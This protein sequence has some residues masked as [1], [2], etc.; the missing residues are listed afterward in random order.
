MTKIPACVVAATLLLSNWVAAAAQAQTQAQAQTPRVTL[1]VA[2]FPDLDRAARAALPRWNQL[3]PG[4]AVKI[5][6]LQYP[7]HHTAM[8]TALATGSGLPDVMAVDFRFIGRFAEGGGLEDLNGAPYGAGALRDKFVRYTFMQATSSTG[9]LAAMPADIGPGTLLYRKDLMDKAGI[10]EA[11]LTRSW[12]SYIE[13]GKKLKAATGAYL[14]ADS[15]DIRN[16]VMRT[17]LAQD[18]GIYFDRAGK[19]LV[20][21]PRFVRAFELGRMVRQAGLDAR[22]TEWTNE[23]AAGFKQDRIA[24]QMM[25]AWLAGH[26]KNWLAPDAAG[27]WRSA[28]LPGGVL[29]SYGGSF[30][31]IPKKAAHKPEAWA[32]IRFMTTER[33]TQLESLR[34]LDAF[35]ALIEAHADPLFDE[36]IAYLGGQRARQLW[37]DIAAKVPPVPV[38]KLDSMATDIIRAE[39]DNVVANGKDIKAAL[40]DARALIERRARR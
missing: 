23:W 30:Y 11:E 18:E 13:A 5:V 32:F 3:H 31:A 17:G 35:P 27:R 29:A 24:T 15:A 19:V 26:L 8:T 40:A 14:M 1:S 37:R 33:Q 6:S 39:Y 9:A 20:E 21:S 36:P 7:D 22:A 2:T 38:H 28:P 4:I 16:I 34:A 25:G 12:E 10:G